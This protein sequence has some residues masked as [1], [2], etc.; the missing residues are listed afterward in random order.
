M[1]VRVRKKLL[2]LSI[3]ITFFM[4][5]N[6]ALLTTLQ[7]ENKTLQTVLIDFKNVSRDLYELHRSMLNMTN[8]DHAFIAT[9]DISF[10]KQFMQSSKDF[11]ANIYSLKQSVIS[12]PLAYK[13]LEEIEVILL[14]WLDVSYPDL[15][16]H[17]K[18]L[19]SAAHIRQALN[20]S[21]RIHAI[22]EMTALLVQVKDTWYAHVVAVV[23]EVNSKA[24][25]IEF[26]S[27]AMTLGTIILLIVFSFWISSGLVVRPPKDA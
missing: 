20:E 8:A 23:A 6:L 21:V 1:K 27:I 2:L 15:K 4:V 13:M 24:R 5:V 26:R 3:I 18:T 19:E 16:D 12:L 14:K 25:L 9:G 11:K 7:N 10:L 22:E 17:Q